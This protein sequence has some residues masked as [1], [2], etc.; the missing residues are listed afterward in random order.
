GR[1]NAGIARALVVTPGA[2]EKHVTSIFSKLGLAPGE[3]DHR[4]VLAVLAWLQ[5]T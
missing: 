5:S 4:R 1:T 2:V 3:D